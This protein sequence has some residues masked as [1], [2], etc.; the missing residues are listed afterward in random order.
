[1]FIQPFGDPQRVRVVS[2]DP[3]G[4]RRDPS[5]DQPGV[6]GAD[7]CALPADGPLE[8]PADERLRTDHDAAQG[9]PVSA[10]ELRCGVD[11]DVDAELDGTLIHRRGKGVVE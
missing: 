7:T 6:E 8:H 3:Q 2:S 5:S 9:V 1:M 10:Q 11:D 4:Q